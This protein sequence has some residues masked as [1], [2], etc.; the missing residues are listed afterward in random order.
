MWHGR[1]GR[2]RWGG[3]FAV[4]PLMAAWLLGLHQALSE[5]LPLL[6]IYRQRER[7]RE[8]RAG[9]RRCCR[10]SMTRSQE[11]EDTSVTGLTF[12]SLGPGCQERPLCAAHTL[13]WHQIEY[14]SFLLL[15]DE[16]LSRAFILRFIQHLQSQTSSHYWKQIMIQQQTS[17]FGFF[18]PLFIW[19][20]LYF[21]LFVI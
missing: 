9:G 8:R 11:R 20:I 2:G 18:G 14:K 1:D 17:V 21:F 10:C 16:H 7:E 5:H 3:C 19:F 13:W 4:M 6:Y 12:H 15:A